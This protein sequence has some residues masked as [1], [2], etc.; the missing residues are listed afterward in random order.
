M[1]NRIMGNV[2]HLITR[3]TGLFIMF[4]CVQLVA[5][6]VILFGYGVANHYN[7]KIGEVEGTSLD[8]GIQVSYVSRE[9]A[10]TAERYYMFSNEVVK[11]L[12]KKLRGMMTLGK[13]DNVRYNAMMD[14]KDNKLVNS[15]Y[16]KNS[17][18][19]YVKEGEI[20]SDDEQGNGAKVVLVGS[21]IDAD[22]YLEIMGEK[23]K[24]KG[25]MDFMVYE[26]EIYL[27]YNSI[28]KEALCTSAHIYLTKPINEKE[29]KKIKAAMK[30]Y[31]GDFY[32]IDEF[33]GINNEINNRVYRSVIIVTGLLMIVC[34]SNYCI[35]YRYILERRRRAF[36]V[37][38]ICGCTRGRAMC[39]YMIEMIIIS[40]VTL[41]SS[42]VIFNRALYPKLVCTFEYMEYYFEKDTYWTIGMAYMIVLICAYVIL[43]ARYVKNT[44][45]KLIKEV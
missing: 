39:M 9:D 33:N 30:A 19:S 25:I 38:R 18:S 11:I 17:I 36:A 32:E 23:Y 14:I 41:I 15:D 42:I 1:I 10:C 20:F 12:Q 27:P 22:D 28:P 2:K 43:A 35:I 3:N 5:V 6:S 16:V 8:Y 24:V 44:P 4:V 21:K 31:L 13:C 29:Y 26:K 37:M 40:I 34:A 45:V 7:T